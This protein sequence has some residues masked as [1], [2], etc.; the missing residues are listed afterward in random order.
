[1]RLIQTNEL[2]YRSVAPTVIPVQ[3]QVDPI[4]L[5]DVLYGIFV[6]QSVMKGAF[7]TGSGEPW[8]YYEQRYLDGIGSY[9]ETDFDIAPGTHVSL[10][11][12]HGNEIRTPMQ[13]RHEADALILSCK[14]W[15]KNAPEEG[16][17]ANAYVGPTQLGSAMHLLITIFRSVQRRGDGSDG[18]ANAEIYGRKK[19]EVSP[20]DLIADVLG[21]PFPKVGVVENIEDAIAYE[22]LYRI[23]AGFGDLDFYS[24]ESVTSQLGLNEGLQADA[25][26]IDVDLKSDAPLTFIIREILRRTISRWAASSIGPS[27][28]SRVR[29]KYHY[30]DRSQAQ[31]L[32]AQVFEGIRTRMLRTDLASDAW[33]ARFQAELN[34]LRPM[35]EHRIEQA[36]VAADYRERVRVATDIF[37]RAKQPLS[38]LFFPQLLSFFKGQRN[39][40]LVDDIMAAALQSR[41]YYDDV[42]GP[43]SVDFKPITEMMNAL[44]WPMLSVSG[45]RADRKGNLKRDFVKR[46]ISD[47]PRVIHRDPRE[48]PQKVLLAAEQRT[49]M[50]NGPVTYGIVHEFEKIDHFFMDKD[51][52]VLRGLLDER[53]NDLHQAIAHLLRRDVSPETMESDERMAA[54]I[55]QTKRVLDARAMLDRGNAAWSPTFLQYLNLGVDQSGHLHVLVLEDEETDFGLGVFHDGL[56]HTYKPVTKWSVEGPALPDFDPNLIEDHRATGELLYRVNDNMLADAFGSDALYVDPQRMAA[57]RLVFSVGDFVKL[58]TQMRFSRPTRP[59]HHCFVNPWHAARL[60]RGL[61]LL[62]TLPV[63]A[64]YGS[65][66]SEIKSWVRTLIA[67]IPEYFAKIAKDVSPELERSVAGLRYANDPSEMD[68]YLCRYPAVRDV[69]E[70][71]IVSFLMAD[72]IGEATMVESR[73]FKSFTDDLPL[74][75]RSRKNV[76]LPQRIAEVEEWLRDQVN[77]VILRTGQEGMIEVAPTL[78]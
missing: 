45:T 17:W 72:L 6:C 75:K 57:Q 56:Y 65:F 61:H 21:L 14:E 27:D 49:A 24:I 29:A 46:I 1:M 12:N 64:E 67:R 3:K 15:R 59:E 60:I 40:E 74:H 55:D 8:L 68:D 22:R 4:I 18:A 53:L 5:P 36:D 38:T 44:H 9:V 19:R 52:D 26:L 51:L 73:K 66:K 54:L 31:M 35:F 69:L 58:H 13:I 2:R 47:H 41:T 39:T 7:I 28:T 30:L 23:Y 70:K 25:Q 32:W 11:L 10:G 76:Q 20:L 78:N 42:D 34:S 77:Q 50:L 43:M 33:R 16:P 37:G 62:S 63:E 48:T 71:W